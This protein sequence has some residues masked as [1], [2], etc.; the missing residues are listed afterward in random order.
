MR[1]LSALA[2]VLVLTASARA[3]EPSSEEAK[4]HFHKATVAYNLGKYAEA[5]KEFEAAYALTLDAN[6]LFNIAQSYRMAGEIDKALTT[7]RS[8]IRSAPK[9]E[10]RGLAEA[11]IRELEQ[12]RASVPPPT[13]APAPP[14]PAP[15]PVLVSAAAP[16]Q[17]PD[18][19]GA[20]KA[21][22][23]AL[24]NVLVTAP[25]PTPEPA[26]APPFYKRWPFWT[27]VGVVV[28]G[29]VVLGV[30]LASRKSD[31]GMPETDF[32]TKGY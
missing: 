15:A 11:K 29:G 24:P 31:L 12:Q 9:S 16:V 28:A 27:A 1:Y 26:P 25:A 7:Y 2:L 32:G 14:G 30:V 10:Q 13:V 4:A 22:E 18:M 23:N 19:S 21:S 5:V 6:M 17:Q 3:A 20:G 8:F